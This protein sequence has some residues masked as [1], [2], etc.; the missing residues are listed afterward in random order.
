MKMCFS[1]KIFL[2]NIFST[3]TFSRAKRT[4][5]I[6]KN[7]VNNLQISSQITSLHEIATEPD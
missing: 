1:S 4:K 2:K 5:G 6:N 7:G 3:S